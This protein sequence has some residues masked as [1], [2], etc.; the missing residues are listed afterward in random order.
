LK[1]TS[2]DDPNREFK[3]PVAK[4]QIICFHL[5]ISELLFELLHFMR[6]N[7]DGELGV[8]DGKTMTGVPIFKHKPNE[9]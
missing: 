9:Y 7:R 2:N 6:K 3:R 4:R 8:K 1:N 5:G